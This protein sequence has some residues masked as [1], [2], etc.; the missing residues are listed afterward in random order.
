MCMQRESKVMEWFTNMFKSLC[1]YTDPF[2]VKE[3][4]FWSKG[5]VSRRDWVLLFDITTNAKIIFYL[6]YFID[7]S[8]VPITELCHWKG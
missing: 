3:M 4:I 2:Q 6:N 7:N 5:S 8:N 1:I